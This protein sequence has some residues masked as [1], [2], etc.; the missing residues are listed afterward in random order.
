[1]VKCSNLL[2]DLILT[3]LINIQNILGE[4]TVFKISKGFLFSTFKNTILKDDIE[5]K[6]SIFLANSNN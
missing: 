6:G 3:M 1:M 2:R 4:A 5:L